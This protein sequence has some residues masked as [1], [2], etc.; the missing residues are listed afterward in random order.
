MEGSC[1]V[2]LRA[3]PCAAITK[4]GCHNFLKLDSC[5]LR[6]DQTVIQSSISQ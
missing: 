3:G 5:Y 4:Q 6:E 1:S 2:L